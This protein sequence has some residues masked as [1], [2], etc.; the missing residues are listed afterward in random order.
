MRVGDVI[1]GKYELVRLVGEGGM[2]SV[3]E[4][5]HLRLGLRVALKFPH[6]EFLGDPIVVA[7]FMRE[8]RAAAEIG[9]EHIVEVHDLGETQ[10]GMPFIVMEFLEGRDLG[11]LLADEGWIDSERAAS[12]GV[13]A[14]RALASAHARGIVHRDIKPDN[15]FIAKEGHSRELLKILDFG[16]AKLR[17]SVVRAEPKLTA[18][19]IVVGTPY[20]MSPEQAR[21]ERNLDN[22]SD[23]F[24]LGSVLYELLTGTMPFQGENL[25]DLI[26][27]VATTDP[28]PLSALRSEV[29]KE[30]EA[31]VMKA[32]ARELDERFG[33][34]TELAKALA[35]F[36]TRSDTPIPT[37]A[38]PAVKAPEQSR[39][40]P[41]RRGPAPARDP[42]PRAEGAPKLLRWIG[43]TALAVLLCFLVGG[44]GWWLGASS[45]GAGGG[46][47]IGM[48][49]VSDVTADSGAN[50]SSA[51][52][53]SLRPPVDSPHAD[54]GG[55]LGQDSRFAQLELRVDAPGARVAFDGAPLEGPP[56]IARVRRDG[57]R[58]RVEVS[59][60]GY[61]TFARFVAIDGDRALEVQLQ[62]EGRAGGSKRPLPTGLDRQPLDQ[63]NPYR[64]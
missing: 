52:A 30:L 56:F 46:G 35:P 54:G 39:T 12:L 7:R 29:P 64:R 40:R 59:A 27:A 61:V 3:F 16:V 19:N 50:G 23:I 28:I 24:S 38:T 42:A 43:L 53:D 45:E 47:R 11:Q 57:A 62:R 33:T 31:V 49:P 41:P 17:D 55:E 6:R 18:T 60:P 14:C 13:Q 37:P 32:M 2:A 63:A 44:V 5:L 15:L 21:G 10:D 9:S 36:S 34:V 25:N 8:A 22:R 26:L 20:Y 48:T 4:G 58:H 51:T 1:D